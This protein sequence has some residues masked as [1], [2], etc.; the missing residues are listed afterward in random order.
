[1]LLFVTFLPTFFLKN[2][3]DGSSMRRFEVVVNLVIHLFL[4]S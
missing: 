1:M 2:Y 4:V 3:R